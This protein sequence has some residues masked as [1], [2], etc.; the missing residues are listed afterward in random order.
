M[1]RHLCD[2]ASLRSMSLVCGVSSSSRIVSTTHEEASGKRRSNYRFENKKENAWV[3]V[4]GT[5]SPI[6]HGKRH[7]SSEPSRWARYMSW[8]S[9]RWIELIRV[10][11]WTPAEQGICTLGLGLWYYGRGS[12]NSNPSKSIQCIKGGA[13]LLS[14][15]HVSNEGRFWWCWPTWPTV[16]SNFQTPRVNLREIHVSTSCWSTWL[17]MRCPLS[18]HSLML[19]RVK[20]RTQIYCYHWMAAIID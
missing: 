6:M 20:I 7:H 17:A 15:C 11:I 1:G 18:F 19:P 9:S 4:A 10:D 13:H 5:H 8:I 14:E 16:R 2:V 3:N 12:S